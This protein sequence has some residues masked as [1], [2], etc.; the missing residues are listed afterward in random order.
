MCVNVTCFLN[1]DR[2]EDDFLENVIQNDPNKKYFTTSYKYINNLW[3]FFVSK[4]LSEVKVY[5]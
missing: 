3:N 4:I 2:C 5:I 1:D